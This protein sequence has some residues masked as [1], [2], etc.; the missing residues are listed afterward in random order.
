MVAKSLA[1]CDSWQLREENQLWFNNSEHFRFYWTKKHFIWEWYI[2]LKT[3][4]LGVL[5]WEKLKN[6]E[7][8]GRIVSLDQQLGVEEQFFVADL[9]IMFIA[10]TSDCGPVTPVKC[11]KS[12]HRGTGTIYDSCRF[13]IGHFRAEPRL[14]YERCLHLSDTFAYR[15]AH[16][17]LFLTLRVI[18][19]VK[20]V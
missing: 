18:H 7:T 20:T 9:F 17:N 10:W 4:R 12:A 3:M 15:S 11:T 16:N 2:S 13:D 8:Q 14:I 5:S 1:A 6:R 19:K